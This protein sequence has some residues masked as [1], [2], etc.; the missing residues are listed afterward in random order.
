LS[1]AGALRGVLPATLLV[2]VLVGMA[3]ASVGCGF[4]LRGEAHLPTEMAVTYLQ[5]AGGTGALGMGLR[6]AL[7]SAGVTVTNDRSQATAIL[8]TLD[9]R[10]G[11]RVLSVNASGKVQEYQLYSLFVFEVKDAKGR[12][13]TPRQNISLARNFLFNQDDVLGMVNEQASI[14]QEMER[15]LVRLTILRLEASRP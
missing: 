10:S 6:T 9:Y 4:R 8:N 5:G 11:R 13:I 1:D 3:V 15:D 7:Q 2:T 14:Q 12:V